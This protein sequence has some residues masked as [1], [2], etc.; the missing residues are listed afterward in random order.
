MQTS[1]SQ[2]LRKA[3]AQ[4]FEEL[5]FMLPSEASDC[6]GQGPEATIAASTSFRGAFEGTLV[7]VIC[8]NLLPVLSANMLGQ[9]A[10]PDWD[11]QLDALREVS[12]VICGNML[13]ELA[14]S[15]ELFEIS[16]PLILQPDKA[17]SGPDRKPVAEVTMG[18]DGGRVELRLYLDTP[19][20]AMELQDDQSPGR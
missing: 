13:P 2:G 6:P 20:S 8:G 1:L 11:Q 15:D 4:T 5:A 12:N 17:H 19:M 18:L 16:P 14:G 9:D 10:P 7:V 3:A